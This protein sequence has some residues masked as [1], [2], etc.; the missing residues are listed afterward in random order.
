MFEEIE[1]YLYECGV[2]MY[3]AKEKLYNRDATTLTDIGVYLIAMRI[4]LNET[5]LNSFL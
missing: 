5:I 1:I 2:I 4:F 3:A